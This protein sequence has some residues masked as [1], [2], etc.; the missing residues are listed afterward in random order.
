[1]RRTWFRPLVGLCDSF[2]RGASEALKAWA[3]AKGLECGRRPR[4]GTAVGG[5]WGAGGG[6]SRRPARQALVAAAGA[7]SRVVES[8]VSSRDAWRPVMVLGSES[9]MAESKGLVFA[10][11][12]QKHAGRAKEKV[13]DDAAKRAK[14]RSGSSVV[15]RLQC[16][17]ISVPAGDL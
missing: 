15:A 11:T 9:K 13:S 12:V 8:A 5:R 7:G 16:R 3:E 4:E 2:L 1:M 17:W 10:K 14:C 6:A